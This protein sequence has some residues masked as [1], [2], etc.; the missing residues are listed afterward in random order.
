MFGEKIWTKVIGDRAERAAARFLK[1][2]GFTIVERNVT[3]GRDEIDLICVE[4]GVVVFVEV[5]FRSAGIVAAG[6]SIDLDKIRALQRAVASYRTR[7]NLWEAPARFDFVFVTEI[8]GRW[9]FSHVRG[10]IDT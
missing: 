1:R 3:I 2:S 8:D 7:E 4:R 5:R 10:A 9:E 6:E